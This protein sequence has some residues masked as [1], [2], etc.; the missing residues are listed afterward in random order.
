MTMVVIKLYVDL[1][2][3]TIT[4]PLLYCK[5]TLS[6]QEKKQQHPVHPNNENMS[7]FFLVNKNQCSTVLIGSQLTNHI[8]GHS[9]VKDR[10]IN[11]MWNESLNVIHRFSSLLSLVMIMTC[12]P[13]THL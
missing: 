4:K 9:L 13:L 8:I 1:K 3:K 11:E 5:L 2:R 10:M 12:H 7:I 6:E